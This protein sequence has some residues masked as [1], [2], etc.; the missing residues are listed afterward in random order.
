MATT[1]TTN[2]SRNLRGL[3]A[4]ERGDVGQVLAQ[5]GPGCEFVF[6]R[7]TA[8]GA[9]LSGPADLRRWFERFRRLLPDPA[10]DVQRLVVGGPMWDQRIAAH[11]IIRSRVGGEPH[12][13]QFAQFLTLRRGKVAEDLILEDTATWEAAS[14]RHSAGDTEAAAP[15]S[16]AKPGPPGR[17]R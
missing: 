17:A 8:R 12:E 13:N 16:T 9:R 1:V 15:P 7:R 11:V 14:R 4:A 5:S 3:A 6:V 2:R 10:F